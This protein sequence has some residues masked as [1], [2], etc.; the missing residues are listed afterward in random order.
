MYAGAGQWVSAATLGPARDRQ[1]RSP[2][3]PACAEA[4][5]ASESTTA[6]RG[7]LGE[8]PAGFCAQ[9][10]GTRG[11]EIGVSLSEAVRPVV[12]VER[13]AQYQPF[14]DLKLHALHGVP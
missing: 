6:T 12:Q 10:A 5:V 3:H 13:G 7:S 2:G 9:A 8:Q 11:A 1:R 14:P 4:V